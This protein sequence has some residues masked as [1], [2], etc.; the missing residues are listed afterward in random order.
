MP[1]PPFGAPGRFA[2]SDA[3]ALRRFPANAAEKA[4]AQIAE[5]LLSERLMIEL[6]LLARNQ[7]RAC[8][9]EGYSHHDTCGLEISFWTG[10][11]PRNRTGAK[12][13]RR[14]IGCLCD[15]ID[16]A[17]CGGEI[18]HSGGS[19]Q[20]FSTSCDH[21]NFGEVSIFLNTPPDT[22]IAAIALQGWRA[23]DT[24]RELRLAGARPQANELVRN[25]VICR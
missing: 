11:E 10:H 7:N 18:W 3:A 16:L 15:G 14:L 22:P 13:R 9:A 23:G 19:S 2:L 21:V 12:N 24:D 6:M 5:A 1:A 4:I 17:C 25:S 20:L 8:V